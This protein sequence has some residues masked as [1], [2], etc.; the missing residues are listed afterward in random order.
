MILAQIHLPKIFIKRL[1]QFSNQLVLQNIK[2]NQILV[3]V[4]SPLVKQAPDRHH[5]LLR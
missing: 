4:V 5:G 1:K 2:H 3:V